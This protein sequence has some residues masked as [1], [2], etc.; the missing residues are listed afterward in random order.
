MESLVTQN[1]MHARLCHM[2]SAGNKWV[3]EVEG[4]EEEGGEQVAGGQV[5]D[6][7]DR[8][9]G[10]V[11]GTGGWGALCRGGVRGGEGSIRR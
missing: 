2:T 6:K 7:G 8:W 4:G 11:D 3:E 1:V 9:V 5:G 10:Q